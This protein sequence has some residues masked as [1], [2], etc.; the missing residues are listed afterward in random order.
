MNTFRKNDRILTPAGHR[1]TIVRIL[2]N[3]DIEFRYDEGQGMTGIGT[4]RAEVCR[5]LPQE[6]VHRGRSGKNPAAV[7]LGRAGGKA[8]L[9][10]LSPERRS[11]IARAGAAARHA[12]K[13][14]AA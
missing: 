10:K 9:T 5:H 2:I 1:A 12:K 3:D 11:E 13:V 14:L 4:L 8:R 6:T 7:M